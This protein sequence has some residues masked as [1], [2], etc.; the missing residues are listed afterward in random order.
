LNNQPWWIGL[1]FGLLALIGGYFGWQS[2]R[3]LFTM[4]DAQM[5]GAQLA[6]FGQMS[7]GRYAGLND[8]LA[9]QLGITRAYTGRL[10]RD[11]YSFSPAPVSGLS[12]SGY[13]ITVRGLTDVDCASLE[14][15]GL[16]DSVTVN[17][18]TIDRSMS[19]TEIASLCRSTFWPWTKPNTVVLIGS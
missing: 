8:K 15:K 19:V 4:A 12:D 11:H 17:G 3:S 1:V 14:M 10:S 16:F 18:T 7:A 2:E 9:D 5:M 6:S 13:A